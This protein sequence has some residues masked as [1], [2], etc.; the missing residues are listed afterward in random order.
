MLDAQNIKKDFPIFDRRINGRSLVY[1]DSASTSQKPYIVLE[2]L[3]KY[4]KQNNANIHR[5]IHT[6]S[7]EATAAYELV[8]EHVASFI[9]AKESAEIIFTRN[10]TEA[11]NLVAYSWGEQNVKPGDEIV[12]SS[13]EHHSNLVPWQELC[14]R[15]KA[16]LRVIP[17]EKD[18]I[19]DLDA[20]PS[21]IT[22]KTKLVA[23]TQ[24]SNVLGTIVPL[25]KIVVAAHSVGA[26]IL[27]DGAQGVAHIGIDIQKLDCDFLVFSAHKM[28]GP[29]GVGVLYGKRAIL[30]A[31]PPF[32]FGG[33][34]VKEVHQFE[35]NWNDLPWKFEAGTPN[36]ADV[37]AFG[38]AL[39]YIEKIG[40][41][42]ILK[43]DQEL[44]AYARKK[45]ALLPEIQVYG[46]ANPAD[47]GGILSFNIP[48]V[49]PHDVAAI[50][51]EEGIA[52]RA[53]H[54]CAQPLM[55]L[56]NVTAVARLS[57]YLYNDKV[58][59][60]RTYEGLQKVYKIFKPSQV[61]GHIRRNNSRSL[62]QSSSLRQTE[63][64]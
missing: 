37:I 52:I 26:K 5:G 61:H 58:D 49:H 15:K 4:Y 2:A 63:K 19:L 46:H 35:A 11:I 39:N 41:A 33:D 22:K 51:N 64:A 21:L 45:L 16:F 32:L 13:L 38:A 62:S 36:I 8:R 10:T 30:E 54:H 14:R 53:G 43:H 47:S 29:T 40:F 31:M 23:I 55:K 34:M 56:L 18:G 1:L 48:G 24:M 59:I 44:Q 7:E 57:F 20:L 17:L 25:E 9:N 6:L 50:L 28:L 42:Q 27:I 12:V 3:E 60:D